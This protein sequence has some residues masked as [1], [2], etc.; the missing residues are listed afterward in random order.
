MNMIPVPPVRISPDISAGDEQPLLLLAGPCQIESL[1]HCLMIASTLQ[2]ELRDLPVNLIFKSSFDKAN[3]TSASSKRGPGLEAGLKVL[4][5]VKEETGLPVITDIHSPE[6][7]QAAAE[8]VDI[9]QIPAFLCR[10]TDLLVAAGKTG[11]AINVKKGQFLHPED[12]GHAA[13]KVS[14]TGNKNIL[15]CERG[16]CFGYRNLVVDPRSFIIM[17]SSGYPVVFDATHSVQ[18]MGG[19]AGKSTGNREY[20]APLARAAAAIG[21]DGLFVECHESP[22]S[23]PSDGPNMLQI[24]Q[25]KPLIES[26]C[27]IRQL[28]YH[29]VG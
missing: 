8:V 4:A 12:M 10:Q 22:D 21:I 11:K 26:I 25:V 23:A 17:R 18:V 3:R 19:A 29:S 24:N 7:A 1:D 5:Q 28:A 16:T 14:S 2:K 15:L 9:L 13:E 20:V 6:Q 27:A